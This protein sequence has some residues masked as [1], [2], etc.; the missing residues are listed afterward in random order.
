V[1][2]RVLTE[3]DAEAWLD[4]RLRALREH[5]DAFGR[6]P[7]EDNSLQMWRERLRTADSQRDGFVLGAL[8]PGLVGVVG[9]RREAGQKT[10]HLA[11]LWGMYVV[12]D[13]RRR[14]IGRQ[15]L[16]ETIA[17]PAGGRTWTI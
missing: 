17:R 3:A 8:D 7:E 15:L 13:V 1:D 4:L 6:T 12:P 14:G 11:F 10:G 16:L 9:C 2:I 5:P